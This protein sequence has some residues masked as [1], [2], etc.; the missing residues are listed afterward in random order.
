MD[1]FVL[2]SMLH[3][4]FTPNQVAQITGEDLKS[5][6]YTMGRYAYAGFIS[7]PH[8][9]AEE[10]GF[11][12]PLRPPGITAQ[13]FS[14]EWYLQCDEKFRAKMHDE[15]RSSHGVIIQHVESGSDPVIHLSSTPQNGHSAS[16]ATTAKRVRKPINAKALLKEAIEIT[17][18]EHRIDPLV[19]IRTHQGNHEAVN[20]ARACLY[21][22][23]RMS[24]VGVT[25]TAKLLGVDH[26]TIN[27]VLKRRYPNAQYPPKIHVDTELT[28]DIT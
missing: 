14:N 12:L 25:Q 8:K 5:I 6:R 3:R 15:I 20:R 17:A 23:M 4:G 18:K 7:H 24:G 2:R 16:I 19:L 21:H 27:R 13:H 26:T 10:Q 11:E 9:I 28:H 1:K 22:Y